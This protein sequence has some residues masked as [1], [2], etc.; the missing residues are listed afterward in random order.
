MK[1]WRP[2]T[3]KQDTVATAT[4]TRETSNELTMR[5]KLSWFMIAAITCFISLMIFGL[6]IMIISGG[7]AQYILTTPSTYDV[8]Q[9]MQQIVMMSSVACAI[10]VGVM[11]LHILATR[12]VIQFLKKKMFGLK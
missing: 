11:M 8:A 6:E 10:T 2:G 3:N 4:E 12:K 1:A 7:A 9:S 5:T